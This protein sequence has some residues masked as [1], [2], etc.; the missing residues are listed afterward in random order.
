[1]A[2]VEAAA[3]PM[4]RKEQQEKGGSAVTVALDLNGSETPDEL[5]NVICR[6]AGINRN[7]IVLT[8]ASPPTVRDFQ[9]SELVKYVKGKTPQEKGGW[10]ATSGRKEG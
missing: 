9:S 7:A 1:M 6:K 10:A 2:Q 3:V 8:W 5:L 4:S